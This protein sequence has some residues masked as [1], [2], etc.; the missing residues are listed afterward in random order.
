MRVSGH[1]L[2]GSCKRIKMKIGV[3]KID[4][5]TFRK[6]SGAHFNNR[7]TFEYCIVGLKNILTTFWYE[8]LANLLRNYWEVIEKF[9]N[10]TKTMKIMIYSLSCP[11]LPFYRAT[12]LNT[13]KTLYKSSVISSSK[14]SVFLFF[15]KVAILIDST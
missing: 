7:L 4:N 2:N 11:T 3:F 10:K 1:L 5:S 14:E 9:P 6:C 15:K 8:D 12:L 13:L